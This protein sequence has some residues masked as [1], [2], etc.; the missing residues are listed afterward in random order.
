MLGLFYTMW[1]AAGLVMAAAACRM[2]AN[3]IGR[4]YWLLAVYLSVYSVRYLCMIPLWPHQLLYR[5][6][7]EVTMAP[8]ILLECAAVISVFF[9][10]VENYKRFRKVAITGIAVLVF[11]GIIIA[12]STRNVGV[13]MLE[14]IRGIL[15]PWQRYASLTLVGVLAGISLLLPRTQ[16]LPLRGSAQRALAILTVDSTQGLLVASLIM[17]LSSRT[18]HAPIWMRWF[19]TFLPMLFR[20]SVGALWLLWMTPAS[21]ADPKVVTLSPEEVERRR[22]EIVQRAH[23]LIAEVRDVQRRLGNSS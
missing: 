6:V 22:M 3:G 12:W 8:L 17:A 11:L 15:L 4:R 16:Y 7:Y 1:C 5:T 2:V 14:G 20:M 13:P 10:L 18:A 21:D 9:V 23:L 19:F